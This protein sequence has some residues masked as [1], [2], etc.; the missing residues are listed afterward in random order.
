M[1]PHLKKILSLVVLSA[2]LCIV[3]AFA[4]DAPYTVSD[5]HVD[6][7]GSSPAEALNAAMAQGRPKA[8]QTLYRRL[9][10]QADWARQPDLD[11]AALIRILRDSAISNERRSTTRYVADVTYTFNSDA[12]NRLLQQAGI[13][14]AQ[15]VAKRI[16]IVPMSPTFQTG[17]WAQALNAPSLKDSVV[18]FAVAEG[19]DA[20]TL[21]SVT[22][23]TASW[24]DVA[25]AARRIGATEAALTQVVYANNKVTVNVRR[26]GLG[27]TAV[28][29]SVDVPLQQT[30]STTYPS[31]AVAAIG[32][33][34]DMWKSR[35]A[36][37]FTQRGRLVVDVKLASLAQWGAIQTSLAGAD[38][39]TSVTV[40]AMDIGFAR[41][42]LGYQGSVEQLRD[43]L[44]SAGLALAPVRGGGWTLA[45]SGDQ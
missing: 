2:G 9:T 25:A 12:V 31:A 33:I 11:P 44:G 13:P 37:D 4:A 20:A 17:P 19:T 28:K 45:M 43:T 34:E 39:V 6:A 21:G 14:F 38:D 1:F 29:A 27:E 18:P 10:R 5:I 7:T 40:N 23:D 35:A 32:V 26:I 22:F 3:P 15:G 16:L 36:I 30:I 42:T 24:N 41:I 8:W